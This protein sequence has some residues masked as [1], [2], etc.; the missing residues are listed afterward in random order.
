VSFQL[1]CRPSYIHDEE[2]WLCEDLNLCAGSGALNSVAT[3]ANQNRP[4]A[5]KEK[6]AE[7]FVTS[8]ANP[9]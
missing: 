9:P 1:I 2:C 8:I 5:C 6:R 4:C 3:V 7:A